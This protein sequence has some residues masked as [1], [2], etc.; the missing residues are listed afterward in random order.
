MLASAPDMHIETITA[1]T[2]AASLC[3]VAILLLVSRGKAQT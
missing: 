1:L 3:S 2:A